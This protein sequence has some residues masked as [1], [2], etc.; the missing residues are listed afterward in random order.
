MSNEYKE[1]FLESRYSE[2]I[3]QGYSPKDS[4]IMAYEDLEHDQYDYVPEQ[5]DETNEQL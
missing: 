5:E 4:E 3:E 1:Q 2:Y